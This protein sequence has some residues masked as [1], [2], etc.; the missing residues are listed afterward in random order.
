MQTVRTAI[1][2]R[3]T[4]ETEVFVKLNLDG[5]GNSKILSGR[6]FFDHMLSAFAKQGLFD[7]EIKS[8]GDLDVDEH[9][10]IEDIAITL[11]Q[12]FRQALENKKG[13]QR[14]GFFE[15]PMDETLARVAVD[16]SGRGMLIF[17]AAFI[18]ETVGGMPTEMVSHFFESFA[19]SCECTLN[20]SVC[21]INEHHKIE[22]LFKAFAR[23]MKMA[24][25]IELRTS[26]K[27]PSTKG[28]L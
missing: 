11:G 10:T 22:A 8:S 12:A 26:G 28:C 16:L 21:G 13:I 15:I 27:I 9:H 14:Y 18:R 6:G 24:C 17:K 2:E 7:I 23:A 5:E 3:K 1:I 25:S 20:V 19:K 4:R